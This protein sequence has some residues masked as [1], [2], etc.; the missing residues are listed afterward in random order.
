MQAW[1]KN[2]RNRLKKK[3]RK[4]NKICNIRVY[5]KN[6]QNIIKYQI[7]GFLMQ[8][9]LKHDAMEY[10]CYI[11]QEYNSKNYASRCHFAVNFL[12]LNY[13]S[14]INN[15]VPVSIRLWTI[16]LIDGARA[17]NKSFVQIPT[18]YALYTKE[19]QELQSIT[20]KHVKVVL[21]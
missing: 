21:K 10:L 14:I 20:P 12:T 3:R 5:F 1:Q 9:S 19:L 18:R 15:S 2:P 7:W 11:V 8:L 4:K 13:L 17:Q 6:E 16:H